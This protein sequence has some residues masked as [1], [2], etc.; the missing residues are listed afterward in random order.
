M[1]I[2]VAT[3]T[4][5]DNP[6]IEIIMCF[7]FTPLSG[8]LSSFRLAENMDHWT[9]HIDPDPIPFMAVIMEGVNWT[10]DNNTGWLIPE[11]YSIKH[12]MNSMLMN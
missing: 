1:Q 10:I 5:P 2:A 4:R 6:R 8:Y 3:A 7:T 11:A 12:Q 9:N